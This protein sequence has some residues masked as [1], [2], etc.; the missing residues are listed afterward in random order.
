MREKGIPFYPVRP[1]RSRTHADLDADRS[2]VQHDFRLLRRPRINVGTEH[3][4]SVR[5][6]HDDARVP[7]RD[8]DTFN[9]TDQVFFSGTFDPVALQASAPAPTGPN[10]ASTRRTSGRSGGRCGCRSATP[11]RHRGSAGEG[12]AVDPALRPPLWARLRPRASRRA[13]ARMRDRASR[14]R[15][16]YTEKSGLT[17]KSLQVPCGLWLRP[18]A[19][20]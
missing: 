11:S 17:A 3:R 9:V 8:R 5:P 7:R 13:T 4:E 18:R 20:S 6:G 1:R 2:V 12:R 14:S 15:A 16:W 19:V 10:R